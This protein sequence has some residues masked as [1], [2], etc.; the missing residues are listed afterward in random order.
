MRLV[1]PP[2]PDILLCH[3]IME[4]PRSI[5]VGEYPGGRRSCLAREAVCRWERHATF[6][7]LDMALDDLD[8]PHGIRLH[9]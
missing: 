3:D 4:Q 7:S 9:W 1:S 5:C 6:Q 2:G 8:Y